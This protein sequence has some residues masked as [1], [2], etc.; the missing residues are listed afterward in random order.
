[1]E[2]RTVKSTSPHSYYYVANR[3]FISSGV[4][5]AG[6][7]AGQFDGILGA[8]LFGM[9]FE[10]QLDEAVDQLRVRKPRGFP[11]LRVHADGGEAR[12]GVELIY[13]NLVGA[14]FEEKVT[15]SHA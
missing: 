6:G 10:G 4:E 1:M 12:N 2:S 7:A 9:K 3:D 11:Q 5:R 8:R 15:A 13:E 14:A